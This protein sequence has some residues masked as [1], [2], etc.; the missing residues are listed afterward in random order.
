[1]RLSLRNESDRLKYKLCH[2]SRK[3]QRVNL[4]PFSVSTRSLPCVLMH[5]YTSRSRGVVV[6]F[7]L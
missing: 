4:E 6:T 2:L 5:D 7:L 1:M 3:F